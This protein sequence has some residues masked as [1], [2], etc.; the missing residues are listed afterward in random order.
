MINYWKQVLWIGGIYW[1]F[2]KMLECANSWTL[3][4]VDVG[5]SFFLLLFLIPM[6]WLYPVKKID[7]SMDKAPVLSTFVVAVGWAPYFAGLM[8]L[9]GALSVLVPFVIT[10]N[11]SEI[12]VAGVFEAII[13]TH[14][15]AEWVLLI[16]LLLTMIAVVVFKKSVA[17][18]LDKRFRLV[19]SNACNIQ[20][21]GEA[22]KI[23]AKMMYECK[24]QAKAKKTVAKKSAVKKT[25]AKTKAKATSKKVI[26][27]TD[28][29]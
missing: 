15:V 18:C 14:K 11:L 22:A 26:Q 1:L 23:S 20:N 28:K 17:G 16:V 10:G 24:E 21:A 27:K 9:V 3:S 25:M 8:F 12:Y 7:E 4:L 29:K 19:E 6:I 13:L 5:L 2:A